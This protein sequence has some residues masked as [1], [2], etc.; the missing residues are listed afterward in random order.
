MKNV[1]QYQPNNDSKHFF[2][3]AV[4]DV[5]RDRKIIILAS[6]KMKREKNRL[7]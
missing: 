1:D 3:S 6:L 2:F 5:V 7:Q 4:V